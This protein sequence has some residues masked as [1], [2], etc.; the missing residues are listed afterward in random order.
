MFE[1]TNHTCI[2]SLFVS[3]DFIVVV[4][5]DSIYIIQNVG[6]TTS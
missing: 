1:S 6:K 5:A 2:I 4:L 3:Y